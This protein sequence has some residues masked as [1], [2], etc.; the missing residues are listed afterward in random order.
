MIMPRIMLY[1]FDANLPLFIQFRIHGAGHLIQCKN[2]TCR[3]P[4]Y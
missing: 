3:R 2:N 1:L 4:H